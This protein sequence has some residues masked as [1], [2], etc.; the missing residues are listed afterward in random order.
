MDGTPRLR[1]DRNE[2]QGPTAGG[3]ADH[4]DAVGASGVPKTGRVLLI[5]SVAAMVAGVLGAAIGAAFGAPYYFGFFFGF[6]LI[7]LAGL[8]ALADHVG[9]YQTGGGDRDRR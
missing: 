1:S 9:R 7:G 4:D 8:F 2:N 5:W 6:T 3:A